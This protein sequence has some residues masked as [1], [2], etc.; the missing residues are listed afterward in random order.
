MVQ[1]VIQI[2]FISLVCL[3]SLVSSVMFDLDTLT[4]IFTGI[5]ALLGIILSKNGTIKIRTADI[6]FTIAL[7]YGLVNQQTFNLDIVIKYTVFLCIWFYAKLTNSTQLRKWFVFA[8]VFTAVIHTLAAIMQ[9]FHLLPNQNSF[10]TATALFDNPGP[11]GC[12]IICISKI[13]TILY[14][15]FQVLL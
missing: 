6:L 5:A 15:T 1:K 11:Y 4:F 2:S 7:T 14:F 10:F 13:H 8:I 3:S 12:Y 9:L